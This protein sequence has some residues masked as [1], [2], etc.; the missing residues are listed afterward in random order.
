MKVRI[1]ASIEAINEFVLYEDIPSMISVPCGRYSPLFLS[2]DDYGKAKPQTEWGRLT[3]VHDL[4]ELEY[5]PSYDHL[6]EIWKHDRDDILKTE[7]LLSMGKLKD[8][9]LLDVIECIINKSLFF[10][11]SWSE[12]LMCLSN[13][14]SQKAMNLL[15]NIYYET[16]YLNSGTGI[17][18]ESKIDA[19]FNAGP[20]SLVLEE[21][22]FTLTKINT[23]ESISLIKKIGHEDKEN[24][25]L[26]RKVRYSLDCLE[27]QN[28]G[29]N[30]ILPD[31]Q[32]DPVLIR[33]E[34]EMI[35]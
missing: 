21:M 3:W 29:R 7:A 28:K 17:D 9:R 2:I 23:Q 19:K 13:F 31:K 30:L 25:P 18:R 8:E 6:N 33:E 26:I 12:Y 24:I 5:K 35:F 22:I 20:M 32:L 34:Y 11:D 16:F 27:Q 1:I 10:E 15:E 14:K 4:G